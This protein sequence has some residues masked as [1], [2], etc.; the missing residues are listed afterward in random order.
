MKVESHLKA[1]PERLRR[2]MAKRFLNFDTEGTTYLDISL[3]SEVIAKLITFLRSCFHL[4]TPEQGTLKNVSFL[5][6]TTTYYPLGRLIQDFPYC[7]FQVGSQH[8]QHFV[9]SLRLATTTR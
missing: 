4:I 3:P 1:S 9:W 2:L 5:S 7:V 8:A 6:A